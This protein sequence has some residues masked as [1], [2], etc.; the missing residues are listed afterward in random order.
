MLLD[1]IVLFFLF[2]IAAAA[3]ERAAGGFFIVF[4]AF[5]YLAIRNYLERQK[6]AAALQDFAKRVRGLELNQMKL[7]GGAVPKPADVPASAP[8]PIPVP[9]Q[10]VTQQY[11]PPTATA[12]EAPRTI[13]IPVIPASAA[14]PIQKP[15]APPPAPAFTPQQPS[16][17]SAHA[18]P[19]P[20]PPIPVLVPVRS[21]S[22]TSQVASPV[23][24]TAP[25]KTQ[26]ME[27]FIGGQVMLKFGIAVVV[28]G[29]VLLLKYAFWGS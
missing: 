9:V 25:K 12:P 7:Q 15:I 2:V 22:V 8:P 19:P 13:P 1:S 20:K 21:A 23:H 4:I 17:A 26:N 16:Q 5:G 6:L 10:P 24:A 28:V 14:P 18:P 29:V 27:E 3:G 11:R